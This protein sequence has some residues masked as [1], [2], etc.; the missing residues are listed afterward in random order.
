MSPPSPR[1]AATVL[2]LR[3][4][5]SRF[6]VF[7]VRRSRAVAFMPSAWVFPGGRVDPSDAAIDPGA[8]RGGER[9]AAAI[10]LPAGA[11]RALLIG[12][13]R[14][15]FEE[16]GLWL[17][18]RPP[19]PGARERLCRP[20]DPFDLAAVLRSGAALDLDRL[21]PWS[22]WVTPEAEPR[23]YDTWFFA[24]EVVGEGGEHDRGETVDSAWVAVDDAV[25]R[26]ERGDLPMAPP[27][28]W[29][30]RQLAALPDLGALAR[31]EP[32][33]RPIQPILQDEAGALALLLP[34]H[35]RHP[36]PPRDDL[37]PS[38]TFGQGR[39]WARGA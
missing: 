26:A 32:D 31:R 30:L 38:I 11:A 5:D 24:A 9:A 23:R 6:E 16:S 8:A 37:P 21:I 35:P 18:P 36:E 33:L 14:E 27:T 34:G 10:G 19:Q 12:A 2:L 20:D 15:T 22:R 29:T 39:W 3:P 7:L 25:A 1:L 13:A 4:A 17:G 28:W